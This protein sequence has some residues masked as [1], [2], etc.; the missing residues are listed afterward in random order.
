MAVDNHMALYK[1]YYESGVLKREHHERMVEDLAEVCKIAGIPKYFT[2]T[3]FSDHCGD[4]ERE[5][6]KT[7]RSPED[8]QAGMVFTGSV[9]NVEDR[10]MAIVGACLRNYLDARLVT[11]QEILK[12]EKAHKNF[13]PP[14]ICIPNFFLQKSSGGDIATWEVSTLLGWLHRRFAADLQT[15][16]YIADM[17][18]L[19]SQYGVAFYD[20][21]TAHFKI[22]K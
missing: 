20:H 3:A 6:L 8:G 10:M 2:Y 4:K 12:M 11:V 1:K 5:W 21:I 17:Q 14:L 7:I 15:V 19:K 13:E 22:V 16:L 9:V 18:L